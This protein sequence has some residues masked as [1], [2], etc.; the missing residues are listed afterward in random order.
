VARLRSQLKPVMRW[1]TRVIGLRRI[2]PG[3]VVGYNGSFVATEPMRVA[4]LAVGYAD[5]YRRSLGNRAEVL[6]AGERV[7]VIGRVSMDQVTVDVTDV[8]TVAPGDEVVLLGSQGQEC[9]PVEELAGLEGTI[10]WEV[11]TSI[12]ARVERVAVEALRGRARRCW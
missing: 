8:A 4:L 11:F 3:T 9:I 5:G 10:P 1:K 12:G 7:P 6:L 2:E